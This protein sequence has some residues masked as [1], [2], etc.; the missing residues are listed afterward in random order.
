MGAAESA[1]S[2]NSTTR[3][4]EAKLMR[5]IS[6]RAG[7]VL[8][9]VLLACPLVEA[10]NEPVMA[11]VIRTW[12]TVVG[13]MG[14]L[15]VI[16]EA[17]GPG[18]S[19]LAVHL[20]RMLTSA[21]LVSLKRKIDAAPVVEIDENVSFLTLG[22]HPDTGYIRVRIIDRAAR[23]QRYNVAIYYPLRP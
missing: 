2:R 1:G 4:K 3:F 20:P 14:V 21:P 10:A 8:L 13:K 23:T 12:T 17:R 9:L 7:L 11:K 22:W 5:S 6:R 19:D 15:H 18:A 16:C